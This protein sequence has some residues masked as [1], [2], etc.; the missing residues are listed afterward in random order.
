MTHERGPQ[1]ARRYIWY[2]VACSLVL[3]SSYLVYISLSGTRLLVALT[4][5]DGV[6]ETVT[7]LAFL[8]SS[9]TL[10]LLF[11]KYPQGN[12]LSFMRTKRNLFILLLA[13]FFFVG[14]GE[15]I[16][17]GQRIL[18][19]HTPESLKESN[20]Q[21]EINLHNLAIFHRV[22]T[23][24]VTK[25]GLSLLIT[26]DR[27]YALFI[28]VVFAILPLAAHISLTRN[29]LKRLNVPIIPLWIGV[30]VFANYLIYKMIEPLAYGHRDSLTEIKE[31]V[32]SLLFLVSSIYLYSLARGQR[33]R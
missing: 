15:E 14:F 19:V 2:L 3:L 26:S 17:W 16:S 8:A 28:L 29:R 32:F 4:V 20:M 33:N 25:S 18:H 9:L 5:E 1:P 30:F 23:N 10:V 21:G 22:G 12:D 27:I 31:C 13:L 6:F 7:A 24:G 11:I